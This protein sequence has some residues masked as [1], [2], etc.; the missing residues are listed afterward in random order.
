MTEQI[1]PRRSYT[2]VLLTAS[3]ATFL[4]MLDSTVTNL[5]I[6]ALHHDFPKASV[7][8]LSWVITAYVV[9]FAA[10][11]AAAGRLADVLGRRAVFLTGVVIFTLASLASAAAPNLSALV[12]ARAVQGVGAAAMIPAALAIL[13]LDGPADRRAR[14]IGLWGA[15]SALAAAIGPSVGG[16]L[17]DWLG[18]RSV[19]YINLPIGAI[20]LIS[21]VRILPSQ[22]SNASKGLPDPVGTVLLAAGVG[23]MTLGVTKG[24]AWHWSDPRT[25]ACIIGGF[26][27][28]ALAV[29]LS[30]RARVPAVET[31][32]WGNRTFLVANLVSLL[33]GMA[34]YPWLLVTVLYTIDAWRYSELQAG[35]AMTPG[36]VFASA[37]A[38]L[39]GRITGRLR[40]PRPATL[41]GL[42]G[43]L[44]GGIW[45]VLGVTEH[46]AFLTLLLPV[47][48]IAGSGMGAI[49]FGT[50][51]AAAM[52]APPTRFAGASGMNTM[53]RQFGGALGVAALAVILES[54]A[55]KG[56]D[57]YG[58]VY[59][60]CT[61]LLALA[62]V[63]AWAGLRFAP[64]PATGAAAPVAGTRAGERGMPASQAPTGVPQPAAD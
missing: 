6:P 31:E 25:L 37:A 43:F 28:A 59:L 29:W 19:F 24:A 11:L 16:V 55:G 40:G 32:L 47:S 17:V 51:M 30:T 34:Q 33:Y 45:M 54:N 49:T 4:A 9:L 36:A 52:S 13:L 56:V 50:S 21:A 38:L 7:A 53:A 60:F 39:A 48:F 20:M 57:A 42:L 10:L 14:A 5:A 41:I 3:G 62:L 18:W 35:F 58:K 46:E 23:A 26:L 44:A 27:A 61:V 2:A 15:V 12:A 1:A 64:P 22:A 63:L 8:D